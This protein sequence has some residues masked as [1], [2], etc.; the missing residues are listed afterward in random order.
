MLR[1]VGGARAGGGG[2]AERLAE[3]AQ[4][5]PDE[6]REEAG[7]HHARRVTLTQ[8]EGELRTMEA[9]VTAADLRG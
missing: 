1:P 5:R 7:A 3:G 8:E 6:P 9:H 2:R 4:E